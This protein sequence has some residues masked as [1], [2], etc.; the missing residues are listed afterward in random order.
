MKLRNAVVP[1]L[2]LT[3]IAI[4]AYTVASGE[5]TLPLAPPVAEPA[6][7]PFPVFIAGAGLVE[8]STENIGVSTDLPGVVAKVLV[9][10]GNPVQTGHPLFVL[11]DRQARAEVEVQESNL[12]IA[13]VTLA[14]LRA[15]PRSEEI[16]A[17]IARLAEAQALAMDARDQL[18]RAEA[19]QGSAALSREELQRR[20]NAAAAAS[21][22]A[23]EAK[24]S[25]E[26]LTAGAWK[27][28]LAVAEA[29]VAAARAQLSAARTQLDRLTVRA[30]VAGEI[31]QVNVRP[32][33]YL[34][35]MNTAIPPV[36]MGD[37]QI[38]HVRVDIDENDAWR[39]KP[40]T[41]AVASLRGNAEVK[42]D[43]RFVRVEPYV[44]PKKSLTGGSNER[45]DTR[46]LQ[47]LYAFERGDLPVFVG[48]QMDV[49]IEASPEAI[50]QVMLK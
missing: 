20:R 43:L 17:A 32:G 40:G 44:V 34:S 14:K 1:I 39:L 9:K 36:M 19:L 11:D 12:R 47:A 30:P 38:L 42:T 24:A 22:R 26:L 8:A 49:F 4:T 46:V 5:K 18:G 45:V 48:Q 27:Q 35:T 10:V 28:D 3:G 41:R 6:K 37:T 33:E 2:A 13:E 15:L 29:Q 16:P 23:A 25:L 50:A 31:L 21:A 7:P